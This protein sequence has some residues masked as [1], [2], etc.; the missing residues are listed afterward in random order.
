MTQTIDK[1]TEEHDAK[2]FAKR[3]GE[4]YIAVGLFIFALGVPVLIGTLWALEKPNAAIVNAVCGAVLT[5]IGLA[6]MAYGWRTYRV[7]TKKSS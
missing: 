2:D 7:A 1:V 4:T 5:L 6:A 3:D